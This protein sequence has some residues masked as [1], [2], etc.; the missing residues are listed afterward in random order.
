MKYFVILL[1]FVLTSCTSYKSI[2][3]AKDVDINRFMG[4][5]YV[6]AYTPL[7]IDD[8]A[9]NGIES[10]ELL[11]SGKIKTTYS[12][13]KG[14]FN[15]ELKEYNPM[16]F[17]RENSGNAIWKMQ[18]LWPFKSDYRIMYLDKDY[19][20]TIIARAKRDYF[21]IMSRSNKVEP[22]KLK[23]FIEILKSQGYK[24]LDYRL[25]PHFE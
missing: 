21:W 2:R 20:N 6:I 25:M 4:K 23:Y 15:G 12:F 14:S 7:F 8:N 3:L 11:D 17:I 13:N 10:Y 24:D 16:G 18:F 9:Y 5:W 22:L 19:K 1:I